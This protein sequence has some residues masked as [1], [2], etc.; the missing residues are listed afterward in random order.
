MRICDYTAKELKHLRSVCNFTPRELEF[1]DLRSREYSIEDCAE[2][3]S[4]SVRTASRVNQGVKRKIK[5]VNN[6]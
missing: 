4:V 3:M 2:M 6:Y 1:F 5:V